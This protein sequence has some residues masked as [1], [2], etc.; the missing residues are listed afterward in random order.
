MCREH[1]W[2]LSLMSFFWIICPYLSYRSILPWKVT[3]FVSAPYFSHH[4][5]YVLWNMSVIQNR[6]RRCVANKDDNFQ[7]YIGVSLRL[8]FRYKTMCREQKW[9]FTLTYFLN[10]LSLF[11]LHVYITVKSVTLRVRSISFLTVWIFG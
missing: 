2:Q 9:Q 6:P 1:K 4:F 3:C 11:V 7:T 10:Y 5:E 8:Q